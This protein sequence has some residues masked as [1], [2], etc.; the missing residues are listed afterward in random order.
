MIPN[1]TQ[2]DS[3]LIGEKASKIAK[4]CEA[5]SIASTPRSVTIAVS[6]P[7]VKSDDDLNMANNQTNV[8]Q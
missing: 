6:N 2:I 1:L 7:C 5:T 3:K 4:V 8:T